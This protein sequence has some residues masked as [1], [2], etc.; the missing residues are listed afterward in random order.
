MKCFQLLRNFAEYYVN[1]PFT[2]S[3]THSIADLT[4]Q[5]CSILCPVPDSLLASICLG[6]AQD[7][8]KVKD[9]Y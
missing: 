5:L 8:T 4:P 7:R 6:K 1:K 3:E 2:N 9:G